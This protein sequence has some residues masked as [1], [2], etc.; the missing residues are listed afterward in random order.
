MSFVIQD[1][2]KLINEK[3]ETTGAGQKKLQAFRNK[4]CAGKLV[5]F[6]TDIGSL[7]AA[8]AV[9]LN[10]CIQDFPAVGWI[11][12]D[13]AEVADDI[14]AKIAKYMREHTAS[15]ADIDAL[16]HQEPL[17]LNCGDESSDNNEI[18]SS[19][20]NTSSQDTISL[21]GARTLVEELAKRI[22]KITMG[23]EEPK[24]LQEGEIYIQYE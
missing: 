10:R 4:V 24:E 20:P 14:E 6:Y 19:R 11:R 22:P 1:T 3:C 15:S 21:D 7:Q 13:A 9:S 18:I 17:T 12:G 8:V 2:G 5:K 23:T 16:F